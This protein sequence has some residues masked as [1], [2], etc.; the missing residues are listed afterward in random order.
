MAGIASAVTTLFTGGDDTGKRV[1]KLEKDQK[2][3]DK[4]ATGER[5]SR[6]RASLS[7]QPSLFETLSTKQDK[8]N[9]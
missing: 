4:K 5:R 7:E 1:K 8:T 9:L 3:A 6:L 2:A